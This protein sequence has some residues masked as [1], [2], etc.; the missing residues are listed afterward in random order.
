MLKILF[1]AT[2]CTPFAKTGGLG[3]VIESLPIALGEKKVDARVIM[4]K[5]SNIPA[6]YK[7]EMVHKK[8]F[9]VPVSWRQEYG[10]LEVLEHEGLTYY[11]LDN[12]KYFKR[13]GFYG[14]FDEAERFS[15]FC[16]GVLECLPHL[17]FKPDIL[18]CHDWHTGL[19][20]LY[21]KAFY[22]HDPRYAKLKTVFTIH[23]LKYQGVFPMEI[24][25]D[26]L[27]LDDSF[28]GDEGLEFY[29]DLN[30]MKAGI[31]HANQVTTVSKSYAEEIKTVY[32]GENLDGILRKYEGKL[33]GIING[34][35]YRKY[36]PERDPHIYVKYRS[37]TVKKEQNKAKLQEDLGLP[38]K[39]VPLLAMVSRL[40]RQKG[41]DL[42]IYIIDELM[43]NDVQLVVLG[44]GEPGYEQ[45]LKEAAERH[46]QKIKLLLMF[47]DPLARKIYAGA[48]LYL[49][50]SLFEPCG[51]SQLIALKYGALPIVRETGGLKDTIISYNEQTGKGNGFSFTNFN[52]HDFLYT[53]KRALDFYYNRKPVWNKLFKNTFRVNYSWEKSADEYIALYEG[54]RNQLV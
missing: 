34:I 4:P 53:I 19:I 21:L 33:Q 1:I 29:G 31:V 20:P 16:R 51:L 2:E 11:F 48:D 3:D 40:T 14:Y 18:H 41:L 50:P 38:V 39:K 23:N 24:I 25:G 5:Y 47:N 42:L 30:F 28:R 37:S 36:S 15:Y 8:T 45:A 9:T 49:M 52:A 7:K 12:E 44:T 26:V 43:A 27:G 10:G 17:D 22:E 32:Y 13:D 46:P 6:K 54:L 35:D